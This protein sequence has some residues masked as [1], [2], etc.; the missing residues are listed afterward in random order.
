MAAAMRI[1][2]TDAP[3]VET[4]NRKCLRGN[5]V[6]RWGLRSGHYRIFYEVDATARQV[7]IVAMGHKDQN[8]LF[9][10]GQEVQL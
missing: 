4:K 9:I 1:Q 6:A 10:R 7:T 3:A 2:L 8:R 5:P